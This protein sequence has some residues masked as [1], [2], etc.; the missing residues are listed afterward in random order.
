MELKQKHDVVF[1]IFSFWQWIYFELVHV[2]KK[3]IGA[4]IKKKS[5]N[6]N[7]MILGGF[8]I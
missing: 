3:S 2:R 8:Q 6:K 7:T 4:L 5:R 1:G